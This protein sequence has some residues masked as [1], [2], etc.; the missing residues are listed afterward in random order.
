MVHHDMNM[1][2]EPPTSDDLI[3]P[4]MDA[5]SS[6]SLPL[7]YVSLF[8]QC[9]PVNNHVK[10]TKLEEILKRSEMSSE[11]STSILSEVMKFSPDISSA[12]FYWAISQAA[13][14]QQNPDLDVQ[15]LDESSANDSDLTH[16][17]G[18]LLELHLNDNV[19]E[20]DASTH[21]L[22]AN[23]SNY[24]PTVPPSLFVKVQNTNAG[25]FLL[26]HTEFSVSGTF[27][28]SEIGCMRRY[29]DFVWL[30]DCL[31][32]LYPF[33]CVPLVPPK[34]MSLNG[35]FFTTGSQKQF[36]EKRS[37]SLT[38]F[39]NLVV[40]HPIL[41]KEKLVS[42]FLKSR[43]L[44]FESIRSRYRSSKL[45]EA[46]K[47]TA[48]PLFISTFSDSIPQD[49]AK[50]EAGC[51]VMCGGITSMASYIEHEVARIVEQRGA[52]EFFNS[53]CL[54]VAGD[55][56]NVYPSMF[57]EHS[58]DFSAI[59]SNLE[60]SGKM[61]EEFAELSSVEALKLRKDTIYELKLF[62]D[63]LTSLRMLF[64]RQRALGKNN[65][66][67]LLRKITNSEMKLDKLNQPNTMQPEA[68]ADAKHLLQTSIQEAQDSIKEQKARD[69]NIK[70]KITQELKMSEATIYQLS[71]FMK[72]LS[73]NVNNFVMKKQELISKFNDTISTSPV[74]YD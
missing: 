56:P 14:I 12:H 41:G 60:F 70:M 38:R 44:E 65:I 27:S 68:L 7:Q 64:Q 17:P 52:L 34:V 71:R 4:D 58:E 40:A 53:S 16:L 45:V 30:H 67:E 35:T 74:L 5:L 19:E 72:S 54:N 28:N 21:T 26:K 48:S 18:N 63:M 37:Q 55:L 47:T 50:R 6:P 46:D 62:R 31:V 20:T 8:E 57:K 43:D 39:L 33:R 61:A 2:W 10:P 25:S 22:D 66:P 42:L 9:Q 51:A 24:N 11:K 69:Y 32:A 1:S 15:S 23:N 36:L 59:Q 49:W 3:H 29:R 13:V 73:S